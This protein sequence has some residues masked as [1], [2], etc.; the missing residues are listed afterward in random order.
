M[1]MLLLSDT[2]LLN[3]FFFLC[4]YG[5]DD[6]GLGVWLVDVSC[7]VQLEDP[8]IVCFT[9]GSPSLLETFFHRVFTFGVDFLFLV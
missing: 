8:V 3:G 2:L 7:I 1:Q 6:D 5:I 4:K 9:R